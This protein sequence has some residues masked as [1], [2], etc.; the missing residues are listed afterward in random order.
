MKDN[1][2]RILY[3]N[4]CTKQWYTFR[5]TNDPPDKLKNRKTIEERLPGLPHWLYDKI[6]LCESLPTV[7]AGETKN[8]DCI[9]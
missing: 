2:G 5:R 1:A 6:K 3:F 8:V 9:R 4:N 7:L